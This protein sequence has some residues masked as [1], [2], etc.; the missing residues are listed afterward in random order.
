MGAFEKAFTAPP[1]RSKPE[2]RILMLQPWE[3]DCYMGTTAWL[4][5][6]FQQL[7]HSR[8]ARLKIKNQCL[9]YRKD[10]TFMRTSNI[11]ILKVGK[12]YASQTFLKV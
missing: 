9:K 5:N 8:E 2:P 3:E 11:S 10:I 12:S 4:F 6:D 1:A 7:K